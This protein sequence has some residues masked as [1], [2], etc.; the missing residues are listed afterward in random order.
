M[1][2][3]VQFDR[4]T[5]GSHG[6]KNTVGLTRKAIMNRTFANAQ[7]LFNF[8]GTKA[9]YEQKVNG[10]AGKCLGTRTLSVKG[11][12]IRLPVYESGSG[13]AA[14]YGL[15]YVA[16]ELPN[17]IDATNRGSLL[18]LGST[19]LAAIDLVIK[20]LTPNENEAWGALN[21][22]ILL[23]RA[24]EGKRVNP[25]GQAEA[26]AKAAEID[27]FNIWIAEKHAHL[28]EAPLPAH[29]K[30]KLEME[31]IDN[32]HVH[33]TNFGAAN[34]PGGYLSKAS[35]RWAAKIAEEAKYESGAADQTL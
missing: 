26:K 30:Q 32:W 5:S 6:A 19:I 13:K 24:E 9:A 25:E 34:Y 27:A 14:E 8:I 29:E 22:F 11:A 12:T 4:F 1:S 23:E 3:P 2:R 33:E 10:T 15:M 17:E 18:P 28:R 21:N 7:A 31:M 16:S 20:D 35:G